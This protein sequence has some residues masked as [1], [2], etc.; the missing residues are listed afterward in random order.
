MVRAYINI[1]VIIT[2]NVTGV[3]HLKLFCLYLIRQMIRRIVVQDMR[4][5]IIIINAYLQND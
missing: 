1:D 5:Y 4:E 3:R 2:N